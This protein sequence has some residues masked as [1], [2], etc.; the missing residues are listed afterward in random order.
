MV[1]R[2]CSTFDLAIVVN[3]QKRTNLALVLEY[4]NAQDMITSRSVASMKVLGGD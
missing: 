3:E 4:L 1:A 2:S